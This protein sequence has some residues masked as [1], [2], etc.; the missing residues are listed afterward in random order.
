M[1]ED[2]NNTKYL[3]QPQWYQLDINKRKAEN[4]T[5]IWKLNNTVMNNKWVKEEIKEE[6]KKYLKTQN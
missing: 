6:I 3:L 5:S 1:Q 4:F 2:C